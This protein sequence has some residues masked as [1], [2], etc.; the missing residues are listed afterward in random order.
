MNTPGTADKPMALVT[1]GNAGI[2]AR[3][4]SDLVA[5]GFTVLNLDIAH[6]S[7]PAPGVIQKKVDLSDTAATQQ[8]AAELAAEYPVT[9]IIHNAGVVRERPLDQV[10]QGDFDA[11]SALH[12]SAP[13]TLVREN[14]AAMQAAGFGR[15]VLVSTRAVLGLANRTVYSATKAGLLGLARTW[16]LE[17]AGGG[18]TCNVVCPGPIAGTGMFH[19][20][21]PEGSPK[22]EQVAQSVPVKRVGQPA[23]VSRAVQFFLDDG[24]DFVTGQTLFV[25]GGTSVGSITY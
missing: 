6:S 12:L 25:C 20:L 11:L 8:L 17:F 16:A 22:M 14:L 21:I 19:E 5:D 9:R 2:G 3:I 7:A 4:V 15:I 18:I 23:D 1:G 24:A 10:T 13:I